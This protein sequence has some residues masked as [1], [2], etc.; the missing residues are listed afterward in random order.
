MKRRKQVDWFANEMERVLSLHDEDKGG[1][2]DCDL[3]YLHYKL[4]EEFLEVC[5]CIDVLK[6][7][8][9]KTLDCMFNDIGLKFISEVKDELRNELADLSNICMMIAENYGSLENSQK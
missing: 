9:E 1:W 6:V 7:L 2:K 3:G 8:E 4:K 5:R